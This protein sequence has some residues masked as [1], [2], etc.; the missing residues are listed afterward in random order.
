MDFHYHAQAHKID[1]ETCNKIKKA[2][3][4]FHKNKES[5]IEAG[6]W[7]G[8]KGVINNWYIPKLEF[9]QSIAPSILANGSLIQWSA[10]ITE[11]AHITKVKNPSQTTNNQDHKAQIC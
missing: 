5:I 11:H 4:K 10:D 8:K 9:L 1:E 3:A 6:G 2:L 7:C